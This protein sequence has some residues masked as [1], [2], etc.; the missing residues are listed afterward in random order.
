MS[1][2]GPHL[3]V[4]LASRFWQTSSRKSLPIWLS[5]SC[6]WPRLRRLRLIVPFAGSRWVRGRTDSA[7]QSAIVQKSRSKNLEMMTSNRI[8]VL[9][10]QGHLMLAPTD[11][12]PAH[13]LIAVLTDPGGHP[14]QD[15]YFPDAFRKELAFEGLG[16]AGF[17]APSEDTKSQA[18]RKVRSRS[19]RDILDNRIRSVGCG[20]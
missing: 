2:S 11:M 13:K 20:A 14:T 9:T 10:P 15:L 17:A 8:P 6:R 19:A 16:V 3:Y 4:G 12:V 18:M 7:K 1:A 5:F